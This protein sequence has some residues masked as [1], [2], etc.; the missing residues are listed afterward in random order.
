MLI[1]AGCAAQQHAALMGLVGDHRNE[2]GMRE[3]VQL[4]LPVA[5]RVVAGDP[6]AGLRLGAHQRLAGTCPRERAFM[7]PRE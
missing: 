6:G 5:E 7:K 3:V 1:R 2:V 4:D